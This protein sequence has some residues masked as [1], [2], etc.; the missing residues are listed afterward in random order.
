MLVSAR[1]LVGA[2]KRITLFTS[3]NKN[4]DTDKSLFYEKNV[5]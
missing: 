1:S 4:N 5:S 3:T 2:A